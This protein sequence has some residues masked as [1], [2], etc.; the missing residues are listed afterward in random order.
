VLIRLGPLTP[1]AAVAATLPAIGGFALL[2]F[3]GSAGDWLRAQG[4]VGAAIYVAIFTLL[5]G[6]ALLPT[7]AQALVGG[8]AFRL[9]VGAPAACAG[10]LGAALLGYAVARISGGDRAMRILAERPKWQAVYD[11]LL[12]SGFWR[13]LGI[14][15]LLR[16]PPNSPFAITNLVLAA[17]KVPLRI[18]LIGTLVGMAPRTVA[19]VYIG[20]TLHDLSDASRPKWMVIAGIVSVVVVVLIIGRIATAALSRVTN[21]GARQ[22]R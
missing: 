10:Y 13:T 4:A 3:A 20:S 11:A 22:A 16:A 1:L 17:T 12:G 14:V 21:A 15:T 2:A 19:A 9:A 5:A 8:Y 7:Y 6:F 18:F